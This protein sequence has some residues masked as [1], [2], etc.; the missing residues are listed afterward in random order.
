MYLIRLIKQGD[1][2]LPLIFL[3]TRNLIILII[4]LITKAHNFVQ[5]FNIDVGKAMRQKKKIVFNSPRAALRLANLKILNF[6]ERKILARTEDF[7]F[8]LVNNSN[9]VCLS[10]YL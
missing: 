1:V 2:V 8:H 5:N 3:I 4:S 9:L 6:R 10:L 7:I